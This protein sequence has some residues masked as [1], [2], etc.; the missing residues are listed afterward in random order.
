MRAPTISLEHIALV[1]CEAS[2]LS[3]DSFPIEIGWCLADSAVAGSALIAPEPLW[4]DWDPASEAIHGIT[5]EELRASGVPVRAAA[6]LFANATEGRILYADGSRD[7]FWLG[8]LF[9]AAGYPT[10]KVESFDK[11]L[12][13]IVRPDV[14]LSGDRIAQDL[15]RADRQGAIIDQ[16]YQRA[17]EVAPK[18]HRAGA[19]ACHLRAVLL[20]AVSLVI[21]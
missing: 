20:E 2:S 21:R 1:D 15:A 8:R 6:E 7:G 18:R 12:D 4:R 17:Q 3:E 5:R 9:T 11:L 16:A 13:T 14:K 10:P 19:D